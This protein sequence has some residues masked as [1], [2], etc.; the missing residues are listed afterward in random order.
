MKTAC[1]IPIKEN[2]ERVQ[3]KNFRMLNGRKLYEYVIEHVQQAG[4]FDDIYI[5]T[6]SSEIKQY[7]LTKKL[8]V[9]DRLDA[10]AQNTANGNDLLNYHFETYPHY[11]YY[12]Q[13]F[14]TAPFLQP[15]TIK[16]CYEIMINSTEWDSC[17]TALKN[18]SFFWFHN[19]PVNYRPAMLPRSQ[20]LEPIIEET[21]G[22]YG[23]SNEAI[24]KYRCRIGKKPFMYIVNKFEAVDIN[25][26]DDLKMAEYIG[27]EYWG[28]GPSINS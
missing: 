13:I 22:L 15:Y 12:F 10:L 20:D 2:S 23:I 28:Y 14:A 25:T 19:L 26:E 8:C 4:C 18:E 3:G 17:F 5:D 21:T 11:D 27:Q 1:F 9:I 16:K 6:N 7:A 24:A